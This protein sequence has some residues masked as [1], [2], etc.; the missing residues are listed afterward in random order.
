MPIIT[1]LSDNATTSET[2]VVTFEFKPCSNT[3]TNTLKQKK[4]RETSYLRDEYKPFDCKI[5][6]GTWMTKIHPNIVMFDLETTGLEQSEAEIVQ[7]TIRDINGDVLLDQYAYPTL[8]TKE[9]WNKLNESSAIHGITFEVLQEKNA[10]T[11]TELLVRIMQTIRKARGREPVYLFAYNGFGYDQ[12]VLEYAFKR[13]NLRMPIHWM[14]GDLLPLVKRM[15]PSG[16]VHEATGR[17]GH[18][19]CDVY[20][21][22]IEGGRVSGFHS[23][24]EDTQAMWEIY[25]AMFFGENIREKS[26]SGNVNCTNSEDVLIEV[27]DVV[28]AETIETIVPVNVIK[29]GYHTLKHLKHNM[30]SL[31]RPFYLN[32]EA[33]ALCLNAGYKHS[34]EAY[35]MYK[36]TWMQMKMIFISIEIDFDT[37]ENIRMAREVCEKRFYESVCDMAGVKNEKRRHMMIR[38][39][40]MIEGTLE[41]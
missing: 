26:L 13:C 17:K 36:K 27:G 12:P 38:T 16:F 4:Q 37:D 18:K 15:Y 25:M 7:I 40:K 29:Y 24:L 39:L 6:P 20:A 8:K 35:L 1:K 23:S 21:N 3:T 5:T 34:V 30:A 10:V 33:H 9:D 28:T 22:I 14:F 31:L 11:Q 19:L 32:G 41:F 2:T